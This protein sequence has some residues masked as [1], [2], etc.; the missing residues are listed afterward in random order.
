MRIDTK[1]R[2]ATEP[3]TTRL[4]DSEARAANSAALAVFIVVLLAL[5]YRL[6]QRF[7]FAQLFNIYR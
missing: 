6:F 2:R 1:R 7:E 3:Y 5:S 4:S